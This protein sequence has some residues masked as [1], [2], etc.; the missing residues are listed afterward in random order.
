MFISK[1]LI[2]CLSFMRY[3]NQFITL[4]ILVALT[5]KGKDSKGKMNFRGY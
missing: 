3:D 4:K 5:V 1:N 2:E